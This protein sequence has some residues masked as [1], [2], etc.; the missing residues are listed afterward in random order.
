[1]TFSRRG[2]VAGLA[3]VGAVALPVAGYRAYRQ[4][5]QEEQAELAS[6]EPGTPVPVLE[7]ALLADRLCGIWDV[8]VLAGTLPGLNLDGA[9]LLLDAG[10]GARTV[11]G[12][13]G[14]APWQAAL[15]VFA[16]LNAEAAPK[17]RLALAD[18]AG[19]R[20]ECDA[21]FDEIWGVWSSGGGKA[22]LTAHIRPAGVQVGASTPALEVL[23]TR[24]PFVPGRE[25]LP[26]TPE[27]HARLVSP[28]MRLF[29]QVWHAGRDR[30]HKM[31]G[32]RQQGVRALG[33]QPGPLGHE[34]DARGKHRHRN[35]SGEDFLY[36]HRH[37]LMQARSLQPLP[38]WPDLP[39]PRPYLGHGVQAFADYVG[40]LNGFSVPP[41]WEAEDDAPFNQWLHYIKSSDGYFANFQLWEARYRDPE[42]L[43][44]LCLGEFGS[45]IE[46]GIHDWLHMRWA[47][48]PRDPTSGLPM[49][50][51]R[52]PDDFA[53]RWFEA[54]NDYLGDPFSSHV[55]PVF[56]RF[57][58]WI[59]DRLDDWFM[60]H[61]RA[62]PGEVKRQVVGGVNWFASGRWV[63]VAEPWLGPAVGGCGAWGR[64]NV[65]TAGHFD[66]ETMKLVARI[67]FGED[68]ELARLQ[69]RVARRPWYGRHLAAGAAHI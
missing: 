50:Y 29:H 25:R 69:P 4:H 32:E 12:V 51:A 46:L 23:F 35:G 45:R 48:L 15:Q 3:A 39:A 18:G 20:Y 57:H 59:D 6:D 37:M 33:W 43:A 9:Q 30:W 16:P 36:M 26:F 63:Q 10:P 53:E 47:G 21:I 54:G 5:Q 17:L 14:Q 64:G 56:W 27:L 49:A 8:R 55:N 60:A 24:R 13:L 34:R 7:E 61:E 11:R 38:S 52:R 62:H 19:T 42:Y 65:D 67:I 28:G 31:G 68:A 41:P 44:T 22:T 40:N 58:G 1:M 2:F 66:I